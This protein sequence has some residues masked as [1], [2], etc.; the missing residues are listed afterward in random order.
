MTAEPHE[1]L[2]T[3][4]AKHQQPPRHDLLSHLSFFLAIYL[5][6]PTLAVPLL[7]GAGAAGTYSPHCFPSGAAVHPSILTI[8]RAPRAPRSLE[9]GSLTVVILHRTQSGR[10]SSSAPLFVQTTIEH[11]P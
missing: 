9:P 2:E 6:D 4:T 10:T 7:S 8:Q 11:P 5:C 3:Q 1:L